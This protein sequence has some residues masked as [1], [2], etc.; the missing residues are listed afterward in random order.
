MPATASSSNHESP[1]R[2]ETFVTRKITRAIA[3]I[4]QGLEKCLFLG[5][6]DSLRD[7]GHAKDYVR[8]QWMMLQQE[9]ADDFVIAT[10]KQ[11]SVRGRSSALSAGGGGAREERAFG[12]GVQGGKRRLEVANRGFPAPY[13]FPPP[14][15][16][17]LRRK[18]EAYVIG[19]VDPPSPPLTTTYF[20]YSET[21]PELETLLGDNPT[22]RGR[23]NSGHGCRR[24]TV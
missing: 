21:T 16:M 24:S 11:I 1:R 13:P 12:A 15:P 3:N 14:I 9:T 20:I 22:K 19:A 5:N 6:I 17:A 2:G 4:A 23:R 18:S 7:W 10:G 8:M